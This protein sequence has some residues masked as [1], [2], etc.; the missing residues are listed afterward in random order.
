MPSGIAEVDRAKGDGRWDAAYDKPS[1]MVVP[2]YFL[3]ALHAHPKAAATFESLN[4]TNRYAIVWQ[5][6]TAKTDATRTKRQDKIITML[7]AGEKQ[8]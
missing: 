6:Q 4:K 7:E 8:Y 5:L 1:T 3:A 2:D